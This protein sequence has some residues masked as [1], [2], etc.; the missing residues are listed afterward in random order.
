MRCTKSI[1][2]LRIPFD[3]FVVFVYGF[4][5]SIDVV[6]LRASAFSDIAAYDYVRILFSVVVARSAVPIFLVIFGCLLF[7]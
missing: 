5:D 7:L 2:T 1:N 3:I 6:Q 4:G